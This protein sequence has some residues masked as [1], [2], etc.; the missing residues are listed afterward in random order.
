LFIYVSGVVR[1]GVKENISQVI[2][3]AIATG[4]A[5]RGHCPDLRGALKAATVKHMPTLTNPEEVAELLHAI[6]GY[7]RLSKLQT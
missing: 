7:K 1:R 2:R 4:R 3:Y 6:D 5:D